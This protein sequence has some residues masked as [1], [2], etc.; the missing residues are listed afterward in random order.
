MRRILINIIR[1]LNIIINILISSWKWY[2]DDE[3]NEYDDEDDEYD[4]NDENDENN[5]HFT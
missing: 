3:Y 4:E 2:E 5:D 1:I